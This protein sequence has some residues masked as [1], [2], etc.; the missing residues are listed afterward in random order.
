MLS[1]NLCRCTGYQNI[2]EGG[3]RRG[4]DD[5]REGACSAERWAMTQGHSRANNKWIGQSV[6]RLEDPPLVRG[7]GRFA[8]D[9]S[10]PHQL[11]MRVV[12]STH[13]HGRI[14]SID[15]RRRA[16]CPASSRSG[17]PPTSP[18]CRRSISARA[19]FRAR[20]YRQ[21]VLAT[22]RCAMSASRSRR[23][24]RTTPTWPRTPPISSRWR[25][26]NCRS[27]SPPRP[28]PASSRPAAPPRSPSSARATAT[29]T[30][31]LRSAPVDG[32]A[33]SRDRPP[34]RRAAGDAR[35]DRPLRRLARRARAVRRRQGAAPQSR[36]ARRA[37]SGCTPSSIHVH[38]AHVGG[39]FGIRGELYPEDVLVCVAAM[40]LG[41][42]VKWIEDR[43]EH[44]IAANHSRQQ[45]HRIRAGGRPR[46]PHPRPRR[47][48]LS[49]PG[50]L[51]AHPR[52]ARRAHD[53]AASCRG[54]TASRPIARSA[55]SA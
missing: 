27:C 44:L 51:C 9:I 4:G 54:L 45:L 40:R 36:A 37:C 15:A 48:L 35:R 55:I 29:S 43:R 11:H 2:V 30:R 7:R 8:G 28:S 34:L 21:P 23:C 18:T 52:R 32:R 46:R 31:C 22:G 39:G 33:R 14:A 10:F 49:R 47:R 3:A 13:A 42:P 17:P 19:A 53:G 20:P 25:S 41:R 5:A 24:S 6:A 38:E 26:R 12:R 1:S 50:R 16:R